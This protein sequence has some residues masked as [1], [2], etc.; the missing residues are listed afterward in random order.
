[1]RHPIPFRPKSF[2]HYKVWTVYCGPNPA[3]CHDW[4][5]II[6]RMI[7]IE[8]RQLY[9]AV[10]VEGQ[11]HAPPWKKGEPIGIMVERF[12]Y[13]GPAQREFFEME[14]KG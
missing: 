5:H 2:F 11:M 10:G 7:Q 14:G 9:K 1:M 4:S 6:G 8:G 13:A 12:N 3:E